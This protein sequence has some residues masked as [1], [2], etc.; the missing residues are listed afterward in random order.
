MKPGASRK[1]KDEND[2]KLKKTGDSNSV[3][4]VS[5]HLT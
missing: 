1:H 3:S 5:H 4:T 2:E